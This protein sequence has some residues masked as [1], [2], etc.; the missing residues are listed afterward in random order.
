[1]ARASSPPAGAP[2]PR[3]SAFKVLFNDCLRVKPG[4]DVLILVD[5]S[6]APWLNTLTQVAVEHRLRPLFAHFPKPYQQALMD[7]KPPGGDDSTVP[8]PRSLRDAFANARA[9]LNL[10]DGDLATSSLRGAVLNIPRVRG[11]RLAH[12]PGLS[13]EILDTLMDS[14]ID[15]IEEEAELLAWAM[16]EAWEGELVTYGEGVAAVEASGRGPAGAPGRD[17]GRHSLTFRLEGWHCDP[18]LSTGVIYPDS[19]G[20]MPPGEAFF[21]PE[22]VDSV[23]GDVWVDGSVPGAVLAQGEG[24]LLRFEAGRLVGYHGDSQSPAVLFLADEQRRAEARGDGSWSFFAELGIGL[25][26]A[27][28]RLTGNSLFDE[29]AAGTIHV[30]I[31]DSSIFDGPIMS[32][33]HADMVTQAPDL[34]L[35]GR[36]I[37]HRGRLDVAAIR[38]WRRELEIPPLMLKDGDT[39]RLDDAR[40]DERDGRLMLRLC[41]NGRVGYVR[42]H[43]PQVDRKL[44]R[45]VQDLPHNRELTWRVVSARTKAWAREEVAR[46]LGILRHYQ[47]AHVSRC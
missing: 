42:L 5:E 15:R 17:A 43:S 12:I 23:T 13:A 18:L 20:N 39:L 25:N 36:R 14:P 4:E 26:P 6:M 30:A 21:C 3:S 8:L 9:V 7:W 38:A 19:W 28:R 16:G 10:L 46:L 33:T 29:K 1:M 41:R 31:G 47:I 34:L 40:M 35:D 24:V 44:L 27:I 2:D 11:C 37:I 22:A 32:E 45:L